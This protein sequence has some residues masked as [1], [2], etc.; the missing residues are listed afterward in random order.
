MSLNPVIP[1]CPLK[2]LVN[3]IWIC[4]SQSLITHHCVPLRLVIW[5]TVRGM[6][7]KAEGIISLE[8]CRWVGE[9]TVAASKNVSVT[10]GFLQVH[11]SC[12]RNDSAEHWFCSALGAALEGSHHQQTHA[13]SSSRIPYSN[14]A[15]LSN[16]GRQLHF[17]ESTLG[18]ELFSTVCVSQCWRMV[19]DYTK[20]WERVLLT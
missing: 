10:A 14:C 1:R 17:L 7:S 18:R 4:F 20:N 13:D 8:L 11:F 9:F 2:A 16:K 3:I 12:Q 15:S 6:Y 5:P 19:N